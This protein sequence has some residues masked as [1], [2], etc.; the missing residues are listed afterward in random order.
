MEIGAVT[1]GAV[2][3]SLAATSLGASERG[4]VDSLRGPIREAAQTAKQLHCMKICRA[5]YRDCRSQKQLPA[6]ECQDVYQDCIHFTCNG[7][8]G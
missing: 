7:A 1:L 4:P 8:Q 6:F 5:R 3:A 2:L